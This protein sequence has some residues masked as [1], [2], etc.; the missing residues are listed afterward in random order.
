MSNS[1]THTVSMPSELWKLVD[2]H[3]V[4]NHTKVSQVI[5]D[6]IKNYLLDNEKGKRFRVFDFLL[7]LLLFVIILLLMVVIL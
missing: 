7:L 1:E 6:A 3:A 4:S 5:Q 2:D